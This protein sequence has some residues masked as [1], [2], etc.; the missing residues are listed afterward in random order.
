M[1]AHIIVLNRLITAED[2]PRLLAFLAE[3]NESRKNYSMRSA[4]VSHVNTEI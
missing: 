4:Q 1:S 3:Q 2:G